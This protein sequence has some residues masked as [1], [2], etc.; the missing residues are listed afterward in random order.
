MDKSKTHQEQNTV[1]AKAVNHLKMELRKSKHEVLS[2]RHQLQ[3][4]RE[5]NVQLIEQQTNLFQSIGQFEANLDEVFANNSFAYVVLSTSIKKITGKDPRRSCDSSIDVSN[6]IEISIPSNGTQL[7]TVDK[8]HQS[9]EDDDNNDTD[10]ILN[11]AFRVNSDCVPNELSAVMPSICNNSP[12]SYK[13]SIRKSRSSDTGG[14]Q[15]LIRKPSRLPVSTLRRSVN[16]KRG[17]NDVQ[18][19]CNDQTVIVTRRKRKIVDYR[20]Q[21]INRKMRR[22]G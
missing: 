9:I 17:Y 22:S 7:N 12:T 13:P 19:S 10:D 6:S 8:P 1:L 3:L 21:P 4:S 20:E 18:P 16:F 5:Q 2:L 14:I 15:N 11:T